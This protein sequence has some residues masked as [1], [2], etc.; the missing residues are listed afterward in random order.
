MLL[1]SGLSELSLDR[2]RTELIAQRALN[3]SDGV[4]LALLDQLD[5]WSRE[6]ET[7]MQ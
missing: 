4:K 6:I 1:E 3:A 5:A 7:S 2:F